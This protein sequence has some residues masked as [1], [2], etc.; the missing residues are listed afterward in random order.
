MQPFHYTALTERGER[1][2]GVLVGASEQAVLAEL[3]GKSLVPV[4]I[5]P[6]KPARSRRVT[7][8]RLG[9]A[10]LQLGDML[11]AGV[12]AM[13]ALKVL[14]GQR[15]AGLASVFRDVAAAVEEGEEVHEAMSR[16][17]DVFRDVHI[18]MVRAGERG[19]FLDQAAIRLGQ[20]LETQA[21]L[22][23]KLAGSLLYP[24]IL[25]TM[26]VIILTIVF[27]VLVPMVRPMLARIPDLPAV[28]KIVFGIASGARTGAPVVLVLAG[29]GAAIY[30]PFR[31]RPGVRRAIDSLAIRMPFVGRLV[32]AIA[33]ARFC[34][35]LGAMLANGVPMLASLDTARAAAG[36]SVL[37]EAIS[38]A[39][40]QV[41]E[42]A[43]LA[44]SLRETRL[45]PPDVLEMISVGE[46][47]GNL[48]EVLVR[49]ADTSDKRVDRILTTIIRL[50]EPLLLGAIGVVVF[51]V[52]LGLVLPL[53]QL[54]AIS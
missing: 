30:V 8:R 9:E 14:A 18:A 17:P 54:S 33:A 29:V 40:R 12:P 3:E 48:D 32:L 37:E 45:F 24:C 22:R 43:P 23:S 46:E 2:V 31:S 27:A 13:R 53:T 10:F 19:G 47:A 6:S 42:G 1:V 26:G 36:N 49:V 25:V 35:L 11:R 15:H 50:I 51:V 41:G 39:A 7:P 38:L 34:R 20:L 52:A 5:R 44:P 4:D 21:E 28:T 16:R